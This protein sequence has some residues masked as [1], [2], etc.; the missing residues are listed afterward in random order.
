VIAG[1]PNYLYPWQLPLIFIFIAGWIVGGGYLLGW[2][3]KWQKI[4]K[5]VPLQKHIFASFLAGSGGVI[6]AGILLLFF[7]QIAG[8]NMGLLILGLLL[9]SILALVVAFYVLYAFYNL[10]AAK[11]L[12]ISLPPVGGI[13]ILAVLI[14]LLSGV[15]S[16][17]ITRKRLLRNTCRQRLLYIDRAIRNT[18]EKKFEKPPIRLQALVDKEAILSHLLQCP[19]NTRREITYFY[20]PSKSIAREEETKT[21]R[22]CD[23]HV[24]HHSKGR[25]VLFVNGNC[26]WYSEKDFQ[27]LLKLPENQSFAE[28]L[29]SKDI[30]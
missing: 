28:A 4:E 21:I 30:R 5:K 14:A 13:F 24:N 7:R 23:Y 19:R 1:I 18:Y 27:K 29:K 9:G 3:F 20:A 12:K 25:N 16:Y 6:A 17:Y 22:A 2:S 15:P 26:E 10:S 8:S 11:T